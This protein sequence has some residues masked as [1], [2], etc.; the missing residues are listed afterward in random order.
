L[1]DDPSSQQ[2]RFERKWLKPVR[3]AAFTIGMFFL[4][5]TLVKKKGAALPRFLPHLAP[6]LDDLKLYAYQVEKLPKA[7]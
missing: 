1:F 3:G 5:K 7:N 2:C 6:T 4:W